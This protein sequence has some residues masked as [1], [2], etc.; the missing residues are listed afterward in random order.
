MSPTVAAHRALDARAAS[1]PEG[2]QAKVAQV[3]QMP[4]QTARA[5]RMP[6]GRL[7]VLSVED[8]YNAPP[9]DYL[10][11][12][13]LARK[14]LSVWWGAPKCG[15]SFLLL[16]LAYGLALGRD[17]WGREATRTPVLYIVAEGESGAM[18]RIR[19]LADTH[20]PTPDFHFIAQSVNLFDPQAD[21]SEIIAK[22]K[23]FGC[24]MS[25]VDTLART[26]QGGDE[27]RTADMSIFVK[28]MDRICE[29]TGAHVAIVHHGGW[30]GEHMRG[31]IALLG[32]AD[33]AV[34]VT[35]EQD[36]SRRAHVQDAKDDEDGYALAFNL[37]PFQLP[38]DAKGRPRFTRV[39]VDVEAAPVDT[40][41]A[42]K[43]KAE[44]QLNASQSKLLKVLRNA[45]CQVEAASPRPGGAKVQFVTI[46]R[47]R[48]RLI[49]EGWFKDDELRPTVSGIKTP[50]LPIERKAQTRLHNDLLALEKKGLAVKFDKVVWPT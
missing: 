20:G 34:K 16:R 50:T 49:D 13:L 14:E 25:V 42:S 27:S 24:G 5:E 19:A 32:G 47:L 28:N 22:I 39:A 45:A 43:A 31:S 35:K 48:K 38:P 1:A 15:K 21:L 8:A 4:T 2:P 29:E 18:G 44:I 10:L 6:P 11:D 40:A 26:M 7:K 36:G 12:G 41:R 46:E 33:L 3:H 37:E 30:T 23:Y 9:R 17:M